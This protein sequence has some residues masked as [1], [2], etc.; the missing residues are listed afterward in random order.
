MDWHRRA[1][2][3]YDFNIKLQEHKQKNIRFFVAKE[4]KI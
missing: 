1:Y 4:N 3:R 2:E